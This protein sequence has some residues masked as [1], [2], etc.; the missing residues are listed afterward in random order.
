MRQSAKQKRFLLLAG[1]FLVPLA[2][3]FSQC[4]T[5]G[6][7]SRD[8]RGILYAGS[9]T[10]VKCHKDIYTSY[11]H[12]AHFQTTR[13][14][15]PQSVHG[16]FSP[17]S[18][19][20][21]FNDSMKVVMDKQGKAFYQT[22]YKNG[23]VLQKA[24]F[25][26]AFGGVKAETYLYWK[27]KQIMQL[28]V[29]YYNALHSWGNSPGYTSDYID[30][31]RVIGSRC[32]E[33]H[34]SYIKELP[35]ESQSLSRPVEMDQK[36]LIL[37]ID[38]ERCHGPAG[39]HVNYH[40]EYPGVKEAK[41]IVKYKSLSRSQKIDACAVCHSGNSGNMLRP[42]FAFKPG[43]TLAKFKEISFYHEDSDPAKL[44]VHGNQVQL[45]ASSA[46]F[47]KSQMDCATCH[48]T[49]QNQRGL[50]PVFTQQCQNCHTTQK[51]NLC[52][53]TGRVDQSL[54][55]KC[56]DCHMPAKPSN[57]ITVHNGGK[58]TLVPYEVRTHRIAIY[59]D[60]AK[61]IINMIN[62][63]TQKPVHKL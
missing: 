52:K 8:P 12:T 60:E 41:Y 17:D 26:I 6:S 53:L 18:N 39:N 46:C 50:I 7:E 59:P 28:P 24:R 54:L 9:S 11:Q 47:I 62:A 25:D 32:F 20:L 14:A 56:I 36:S 23:K 45:L 51:H 61:K 21:V 27:G 37:S 58:S 4:F 48:N 55:N 22:S 30:F 29:S 49:H 38:C 35:S 5:G 3:I 33:C 34:S 16:S 40:T 19:T 42:T 43:D 10:C 57:V 31:S 1:V 44:D 63:Q 2:L 15:S 13:E